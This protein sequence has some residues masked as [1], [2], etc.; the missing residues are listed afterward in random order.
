MSLCTFHLQNT[1]AA[2]CRLDEPCWAAATCP[3]PVLLQGRFLKFLRGEGWGEKELP[4]TFLVLH[5]TSA[6]LYLPGYDVTRFHIL[7]SPLQIPKHEA[8]D[9]RCAVHFYIY[10]ESLSLS[11]YIY[12]F[13]YIYLYIIFCC[14]SS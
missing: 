4:G 11:I 14:Y 10:I 12:L 9:Q 13:I 6:K 2:L 7:L 1:A 3:A 5:L 8:E